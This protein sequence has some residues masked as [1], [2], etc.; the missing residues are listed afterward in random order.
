MPGRPRL[1]LVLCCSAL[2]LAG[3]AGGTRPEA[4]TGGPPA[5]TRLVTVHVK[6]M[7]ERLDLA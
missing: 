5:D 7:A 3:C 1:S 6:D 4:G 2:L